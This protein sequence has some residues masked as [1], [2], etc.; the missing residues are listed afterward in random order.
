MRSRSSRTL[1]AR[2]HTHGKRIAYITHL[3]G[4]DR[5]DN[6]RS[7]YF[8][9]TRRAF[10]LTLAG[11]TFYVLTSPQDAALAY[12]NITSLSFDG[13]MLDALVGCGVSP[14]AI[15]KLWLSPKDGFNAPIPNPEQKCLAQLMRDFH[16]QQLLPGKHQMILGQKFQN[17][18][19]ESLSWD[20]LKAASRPGYV[21]SSSGA[22]VELSLRGWCGD[23][24][25]TAATRAFF[26]EALLELAPDIFRHFFLFDDNSWMLLYGYPRFLARD[27]YQGKEASVDGLT[28]YFELSEECRH[29]NAYFVRTAEKALRDLDISKLDIAKIFLMVYWV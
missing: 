10:R 6:T 12:K 1:T 26:G 3:S 13:F 14:F 4:R 17:F 11:Q 23:V 22:S 25:L 2:S 15:Q 28:R 9:N 7:I 21:V 29:D 18:I 20:V 27:M 8:N 19:D 16:K 24:L 5:V